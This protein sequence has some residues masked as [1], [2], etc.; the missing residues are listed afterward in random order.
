VNAHNPSLVGLILTVPVLLRYMDERSW[1]A[2]ISLGLGA[3][4]VLP[5]RLLRNLGSM[6]GIVFQWRVLVVFA[7]GLLIIALVV[8]RERRK[9]PLAV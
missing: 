5:R 1:V 7:L 6:P 8:L 4:I 2:P 9:P 3:L